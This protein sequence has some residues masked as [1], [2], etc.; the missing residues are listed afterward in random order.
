MALIPYPADL[1]KCRI[2]G[3]VAKHLPDS[4]DQD[5]NPDLYA[6]DDEPL[7]FTPTARRVQFRGST[8]MMI[9]LPSF[10]ARIDA[11]GVLRG[12][13]GS[14]GIVVIATNDPN[15]NPTDWQYKV[16]F[17]RG[18]KLRIPPFYIH[19]PAGGT[20]DLGRIIP[21]D[22]EAGTVFVADE[23]VAARAEK[24]AAES[25]AVAAIVRGAGEA[26]IQRSA[27]ERARASA[28]E[29][30]ASAEA[31]RVEEENRRA[32]AESGRVNAETQR[33]SAENNRGF[34]ETSRTNAET[35][36]ALAETARETTEAQ[37][38]E[39]ESER[40]KKEKSRASTEAARATAERLRDEQQ[41]RNNADQA[42]NNLAAQGLQVQILQESQY[43][44]HTL[45]PTI[46][47]TTGKLYFVPDPHAVG[48]NSYI[49]FMW[50]NGK[51][52]RVGASTA[53]F[54]GIKTSSIDSVVANSS[55][56]GE[57]V[58]TLTG[59][60]YWWRKLTNIFAGKSH[61]H[62]ALDITSGTLPVSRGGLGAETPVEM[63]MARQAIGAASQEDLEGAVEAIQNALGPLAETTPWETLPLDDGWVPV[64]GQTPRIRKVSGL[65]CIEGA[66]RQES[67]GDVDSITVIPYKYRPSSGEQIIGS[68]IARTLFN[69]S[70]PKHVNMYV[71]NKTGSLYLG[72]YSGIEF[73]SGWS[74]SLTATYAPR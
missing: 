3:T 57:Q 10:E 18:R 44:A 22:D 69:Y 12:E 48:G 45:V 1:G 16:E 43:H 51:F 66:V 31:K 27:A 21:A 7:V 25:E 49:E 39:A 54:E 50:I 2:V 59:L 5:K 29:S 70:D 63:R 38:R 8:P 32:S 26:E 20:V 34:N 14:A 67:G 19:A 23:S 13:D 9:T 15:C 68:T 73:N 46:T 40:E 4:S 53:N 36:R 6:L 42:A 65:V 55:P 74:F 56:V 71:S 64:D 35:Q 41:A 37:R 52:E 61:V 30:R 72:S 62:S 33:I 24:A 47:G 28:E 60:S 17:K 58:L 11:Q